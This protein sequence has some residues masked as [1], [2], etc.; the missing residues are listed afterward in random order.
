MEILRQWCY[1]KNIKED[2][3]M[4]IV[5]VILALVGIVLLI[6]YFF[7]LMKGDDDK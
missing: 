1:Y 2:L 5:S 4:N 6:Y 3:K 7:I